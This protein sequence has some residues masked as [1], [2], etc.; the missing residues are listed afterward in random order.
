MLMYPAAGGSWWGVALV[1]LVFGVATIATMLAAVT[2]G[3][4]GISNLPIGRLER[5]SHVLAGLTL[6]ACGLAIQLG[7]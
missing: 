2:L 4:L 3:Y 7:F 1:V 5:Y 6:V